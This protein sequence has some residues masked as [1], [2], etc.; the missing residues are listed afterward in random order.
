MK[1]SLIGL[2]LLLVLL[3]VGIAATWAMVKI[4]APMET[5]LQQ[6]AVFALEED[7]V[8]ADAAS[9]EVMAAWEK[10]ANFRTCL[11]D[12]TPVEEIDAGL[13]ELKIYAAARENAAFAAACAELGRKI[14]AVGEAHSL[15]WWNIL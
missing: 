8:Q 2:G 1:R 5:R 4:H 13:E 11:A 3:A 7:W 14:A 12:H 6:A 10:W 9:R 15:V